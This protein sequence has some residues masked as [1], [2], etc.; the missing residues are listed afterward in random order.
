[1]TAICI[2][3]GLTDALILYQDEDQTSY[4]CATCGAMWTE[5]EGG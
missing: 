4:K 5:D 1:M 2:E 3:C